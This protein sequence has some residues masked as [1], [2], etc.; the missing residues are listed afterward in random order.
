MT[1]FDDLRERLKT[2]DTRQSAWR[3][4]FLDAFQRLRRERFGRWRRPGAA[5][6]EELA[7]E[8][9]QLAGEDVAREL[10]AFFDQC[11]DA[12]R[13]EPLPQNRAKLRADIGAAQTLFGELWAYAA[14][15]V[16]LVRTSKDALRLERA[17]AAVS[18]DDL[19]ADALEVDLLLARLWIAAV[20]AEL[21]PRA[22]FAAAAAISNPGT[23]GGGAFLAQRLRDFETS[24]AFKS[25]VLPEL[26]MRSA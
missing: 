1:A 13:A 16:E 12:Y 4:D 17:L 26:R 24:L 23:G 15:N 3:R 19:R 22:A 2:L 21:D 9:R 18:L 20:R 5:E 25:R 8:A 7:R 10:F 14:Q 11:C 6:E